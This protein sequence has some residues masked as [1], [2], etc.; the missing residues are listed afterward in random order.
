[1]NMKMSFIQEKQNSPIRILDI[2]IF[3]IPFD[4]SV[5]QKQN[6]KKQI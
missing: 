3:K 6:K 4:F 1:M 2:N 5:R